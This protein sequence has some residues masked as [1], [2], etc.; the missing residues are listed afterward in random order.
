MI[1][2]AIANTDF[3]IR[4]TCVF[5]ERIFRDVCSLEQKQFVLLAILVCNWS[6]TESITLSNKSATKF[7]TA[8]IRKHN[9]NKKHAKHSG[10]TH[11]H[12]ACVRMSENA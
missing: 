1:A 7:L 5:C 8:E 4:S 6:K 9:S 11:S 3:Y 2:L 10:R 12:S